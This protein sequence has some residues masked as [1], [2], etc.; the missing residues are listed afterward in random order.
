MM[1]NCHCARCRK[2]TGSTFLTVVVF[3]KADFAWCS[4]E[5]L[6]STYQSEAPFDL[7]RSFCSNCGGYLGEPYCEGEHVVLAAG[8]LDDDPGIRPSFHEY[9]AHKAP[10]FEIADEVKQF[11]GALEMPSGDA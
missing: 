8:T 7:K 6:V 4:G 9:A 5:D 2:A 3:R 1:G 10:W 11:E